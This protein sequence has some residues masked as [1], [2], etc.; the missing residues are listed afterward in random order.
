MTRYAVQPQLG[1]E[2]W[3]KLT[4]RV[5]E[6]LAV[7]LKLLARL[8]PELGYFRNKSTPLPPPPPDGRHGFLAPASTWI[9]KTA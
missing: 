6:I 7:Y 4:R 3:M 8:L 2:K 9:S 5:T 1:K